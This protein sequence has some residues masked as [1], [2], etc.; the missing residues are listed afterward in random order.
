MKIKAKTC[1]SNSG[2]RWSLNNFIPPRSF[3]VVVFALVG[4][5]GSLGIASTAQA[6][7]LYA[8]SFEQP[9]FQP[10]D[11]LLGLDG[12][13]TAIPPFLNPAAA[14]ITNAAAKSG[15]QSVEVHGADLIGSD[16]ITAPYD[17]VGSYR[18]PL[19]DQNGEPNGHTMTGDKKLARVDAN[20]MLETNQ[21]KTKG[22]F[23][24]LTI[25]PR[26]G[27]GESYGEI[28]LSS[29]GTVEAFGFN[30]APATDR[31]FA[32]PIRF[33]KWYHITML[34]DF[35]NR[36]T[37]YFIDDQF[38]G[39]VPA[40]SSSD[41]LLRCAMLVFARPDGDVSGGPNSKRANY[42]A[43]FDNFRVSVHGTAPEID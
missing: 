28:G 35:A 24:S 17:A 42:T 34:I 39:A 14:V 15:T 33:N 9:T 3:V 7:T 22:E 19:L 4:V 40:P 25:S 5:F 29:D 30:A 12:W 31:V 16:G 37:S 38:I 20:L 2:N 36:T 41:L 1:Q 18:R 6:V 27:N 10:S 23:F 43:R 32:R 11:Q 8:T 26:S 13:S 21:K